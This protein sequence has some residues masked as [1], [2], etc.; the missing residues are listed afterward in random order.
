MSVRKNSLIASPWST[1]KIEDDIK[2]CLS[3]MKCK[4]GCHW[5]VMYP[6]ASFDI[7]TC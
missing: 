6:A 2:M 1:E 7:V 4:G 3:E 5:L